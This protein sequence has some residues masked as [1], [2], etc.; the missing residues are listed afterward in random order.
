[1]Q[2]AGLLRARVDAATSVLTSGLPTHPFIARSKGEYG[3]FGSALTPRN[4]SAVTAAAMLTS[5]KA[6]AQV[7]GFDTDF[8]RDF[9]DVDYCL[10]LLAKNYRIAWTPYAHFTHHEGASIVRRKADPR[11]QK[12]FDQRWNTGGTDPYY[13]R[14]LNQDLPRMYEAL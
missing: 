12:L 6:F 2:P 8:A 3:Y 14:A 11:E 5:K 9:N 1:M 4:Y 10:K 7:H 13:S